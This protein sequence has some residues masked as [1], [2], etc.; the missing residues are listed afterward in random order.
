MKAPHAARKNKD[1]APYVQCEDDCPSDWKLETDVGSGANPTF[2]K[3]TVRVKIRKRNKALKRKFAR[4]K[5]SFRVIHNRWLRS[6]IPIGR[7]EKLSLEPLLSICYLQ[8]ELNVLEP[9]GRKV[10]GTCTVR[11]RLRTPL[12]GVD[13]VEIVEKLLHLGPRP[14]PALAVA[15]PSPSSSA[16]APSSTAE[17]AETPAAN[18]TSKTSKPGDITPAQPSALPASKAMS[19]GAGVAVTED[20]KKV[21]LPPGITQVDVKDPDAIQK[22]ISSDALDFE[23]K[24]CNQQIARCKAQKKDAS[25]WEQRKTCAQ[26]QLGVLVNDVQEGKLSLDAYLTRLRESIKWHTA[27]VKT[28]LKLDRKEEAEPLFQRLKIMKAELKGAI[29]NADQLE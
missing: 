8:Q 2:K 9:N 3:G 22:V 7:T 20:G 29:E 11:V 5:L 18:S 12:E 21:Q 19:K 16:S 27:M 25:E 28:L 6:D 1:L 15:S 4:T 26:I 13:K 24:R 14:Q 23:V 17:K 10:L